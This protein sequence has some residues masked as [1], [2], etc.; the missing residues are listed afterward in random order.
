MDVFT[1]FLTLLAATATE[2][3]A[4]DF[5]IPWG[6]PFT[7]ELCVACFTGTAAAN[8]RFEN[9]FERALDPDLDPELE[10]D[11][12]HVLEDGLEDLLWPI[13]GLEAGTRR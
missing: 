6:P 13:T 5:S 4:L 7:P 8:G 2:V 1:M 3:F 12:A 9:D 10:P 11:L